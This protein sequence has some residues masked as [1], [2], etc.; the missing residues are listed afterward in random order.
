MFLTFLVLILTAH[1][2]CRVLLEPRLGAFDMILVFA[3]QDLD[4]IT[5]IKI[6]VT[7][8]AALVFPFFLTSMAMATLF[9]LRLGLL[10]LL[11]LDF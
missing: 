6:H 7:D 5:V 8:V 4:Q 9:L 2:T 3:K 11:F 1:R 10:M